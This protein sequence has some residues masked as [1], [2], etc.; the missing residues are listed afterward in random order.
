LDDIPLLVEYLIDRYAKKTGKTITSITKRTLEALQAYDWPGNVRELQNVVER[1]IVVCEGTTFSVDETWLRNDRWQE[2]K[3]ATVVE[4]PLGRLD[5]H[6]EKEIIEAAL[7]KSKGRIAGPA[8]AAAQLG[9]PRT[10]L[11]SKIRAL[12]INKHVFKS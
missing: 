7:A 1:A 8:G 3:H 2:R 9:I 6:R 12:G 11:E 10:T 5:A 4:R